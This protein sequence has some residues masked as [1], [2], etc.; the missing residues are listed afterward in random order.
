MMGTGTGNAPNLVIPPKTHPQQCHQ[1]FPLISQQSPKN[2]FTTTKPTNSYNSN[3]LSKTNTQQFH[4]LIPLTPKN[5]IYF[6]KIYQ[7]YF[8]Q[9]LSKIY[10]KNFIYFTKIYQIYFSQHHQTNQKSEQ[11]TSLHFINPFHNQYF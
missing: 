6:T 10:P 4:R 3:N 9:N 5:F 11:S 7:I 2:P 8:S 1:L